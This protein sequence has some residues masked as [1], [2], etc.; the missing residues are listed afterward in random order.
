MNIAAIWDALGDLPE[1]EAAHILSR[2][3]SQYEA[4][5]KHNLEDEA[6]RHFFQSLELAITQTCQCNSNRR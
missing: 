2:L 5:L 4:R 6:A 1:S 3:F